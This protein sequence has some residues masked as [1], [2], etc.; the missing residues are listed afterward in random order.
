MAEIQLSFGIGEMPR[1][2]TLTLPLKYFT[3]DKGLYIVYC[4]VLDISG[5]GLY[6]KDA[7]ESFE[8]WLNEN[9]IRSL[10]EVM[11]RMHL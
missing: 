10:V 4:P 5:N 9:T 11:D 6:L 7:F 8:F 1:D 2:F 3:D